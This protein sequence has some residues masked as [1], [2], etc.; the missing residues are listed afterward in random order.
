MINFV[1]LGDS[2]IRNIYEYFVFMIEGQFT[3]LIAK[4]HHNLNM[5]YPESN[6][7][8]D[9]LWGPQME[10]GNQKVFA[11]RDIYNVQIKLVYLRLS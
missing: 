11:K 3:P 1:L 2:R 6:F 10:T 7:K 9:F 5:L 8:V 4:P